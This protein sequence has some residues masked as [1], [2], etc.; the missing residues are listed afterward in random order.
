MTAD[1]PDPPYPAD[2]RAKGWRFELDYERINQSSTW[3]L[4]GEHRPLLLMLW[5]VAW[6]QTPCG[7]LPSDEEVIAALAGIAP[8]QWQ[9]ARRVLLRG[10]IEHSDGRLYHP[11]LTERVAEMLEARAGAAAR[12]ARS[13]TKGR[14]GPAPDAPRTPADDHGSPDGQGGMS[15]VTPAG[16]TAD[17]QV[18][19]PGSHDTG[20]GTG[21]GTKVG[22]LHPGGGDS[23]REDRAKEPGNPEPP[24]PPPPPEPTAAALVT[25]A[26]RRAGIGNA[27]PGHPRLL[28]LLEAG[29]TG[30][31]FL[32]L[33][34]R[35]QGR[36]DPF[37]YLLAVVEAERKRAADIAAA[38]RPPSGFAPFAA[39]SGLRPNSQIALEERNRAVAAEWLRA[40]GAADAAQ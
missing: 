37:S 40:H 1:R 19:P 28:A 31:E 33:A 35:C 8:K 25:L 11:T 14:G 26:L 34:P 27:N 36:D 2:T 38:P 7:T 10:W 21:T 9:K 15:R 23:P 29:A 30:S 18:S 24:E 5:L 17:S 16:V 22:E 12:K 39:A 20:T 32:A 13:R 4:A 6:Q 3:A